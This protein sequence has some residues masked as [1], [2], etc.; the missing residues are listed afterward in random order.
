[1]APDDAPSSVPTH[2]YNA[3]LAGA[4]EAKWHDRWETDRV[5]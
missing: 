1:M 5:F 2:R 4:I 3:R